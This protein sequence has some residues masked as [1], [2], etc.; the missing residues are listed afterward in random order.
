MPKMKSHRGAKKRYKLTASGKVKFKRAYLR[1]LLASK[2]K[3]QKRALG[4]P[5]YLK[6]GDAKHIRPMISI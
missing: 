1:H 4:K 6:K 3:G 2:N 5:G